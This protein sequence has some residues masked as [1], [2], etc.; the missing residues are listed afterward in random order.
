[1]SELELFRVLLVAW[2]VLGAIT[3]IALLF[4]DAPYGRHLRSGFGPTVSARVGWL[5][6]EAPAALVPALFFATGT[7]THSAVAWCFLLI[8]ELHYGYRA[9]VYPFLSRGARPMPLSIMGSGVFFN[10]VNGYLNGR[11]LFALSDPYPVAWLTDPRFLAGLLLFLFGFVV[12]VHSDRILRHLR[13]PGETGY[14][15]PQG[16]L[17]GW[18]SSPNYLGEIVQWTG[19]AILTWCMPTLAFTYWT[20]ANLAPRAVANHRWYKERFPDYPPRRR[21]LIPFVY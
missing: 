19:W 9:F 1:M 21:A 18:V 3:F 10:C 16:G 8:W 20:V 6:M 11:W 4:I 2:F 13:A 15:I 17:F 14:K 7:R 5:V 12:H